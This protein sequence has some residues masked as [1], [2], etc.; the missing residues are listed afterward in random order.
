MMKTV[1]ASLLTNKQ[2][3][4]QTYRIWIKF[5][6]WTRYFTLSLQFNSSLHHMT[7]KVKGRIS[8]V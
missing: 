6:P 1:D 8:V 2:T 3:D 7:N 5:S 4:K